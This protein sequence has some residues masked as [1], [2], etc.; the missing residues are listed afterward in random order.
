MNARRLY[1]LDGDYIGI[2]GRMSEP[3]GGAAGG[4]GGAAGREGERVT[5]A[6]T[7]KPVVLPETFDGTK[8]WDEWYF[9]FEN[10]AAVNGWDDAL[11]LKWLRVQLTG[12]AQKALHRL[13]EAARETYR[14]TRT[15]LKACFDPE[16]RQTRYQ[17]EFQTRRKKA[18]EGWA[19]FADDLKSLADKA[20]PSLQDEARERLSINAYLQ[21]LTQPQVA[22]SVRQKRPETL[23][24]AVAATL[25]MESYTPLPGQAGVASALPQEEE[26]AVCPID[27]IDKIE[28]LTRTVERL[29]E[30][31]ERLQQETPKLNC[32]VDDVHHDDHLRRE[33]T[34]TPRRVFSGECWRC[35]RRGHIARNCPQDRTPPQGN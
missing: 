13:Q 34:H 31:V 33:P 26:P 25:E 2:V 7:A 9:H 8:N 21:E 23:N 6:S 1:E 35:R 28:K 30:Q 12:R 15:A 10:V 5:S 20:Y 22:F 27:A 18:S 32:Q 3:E 19:D 17:A 24:D 14:A 4:E 29:A 16:S 11:K